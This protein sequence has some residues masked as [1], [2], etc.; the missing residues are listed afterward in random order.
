MKPTIKQQEAIVNKLNEVWKTR[1]NT[2][3]SCNSI[4]K[5]QLGLI[6]ELKEYGIVREGESS[7][8]IALAPIICDVCGYTMLF[9][10]V[11]LGLV[12]QSDGSFVDPAKVESGTGLVLVP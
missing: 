12:S 2:C 1:I 7:G 11:K 5:W 8:I 4:P 6:S 10:L 3:P 9:N